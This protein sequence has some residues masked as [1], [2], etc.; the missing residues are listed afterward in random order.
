MYFIQLLTKGKFKNV[1]S[2]IFNKNPFAL[3]GQNLPAQA[4]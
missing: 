2:N 1:V 3:K 4:L